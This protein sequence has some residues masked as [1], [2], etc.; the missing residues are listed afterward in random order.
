MLSI[1]LSRLDAVL[2]DLDGTLWDSAAGVSQAWQRALERRPPFREPIT[3]AEFRSLMGMRIDDIGKKLFP[4]LAPA[5]QEALVREC[6]AEERVWLKKAGGKVYPGVAETLAQLAAGYRLCLVSNCETGY[7]ENF[8]DLTGLGPYFSDW[9][10]FGETKQ[11]KGENIRLIMA[12]NRFQAP[13]FVGD[14]A[15]DQAAAGENNLPFIYAAY[16]FGSLTAYDEQIT[17]FSQLTDLLLPASHE[18]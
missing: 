17:A 14:T 7:I 11:N 15:L 13:V 16:G 6:L 1:D 9:I 12:R 18:R 2:F 3:E 10:T 5:A 8:F 4:A